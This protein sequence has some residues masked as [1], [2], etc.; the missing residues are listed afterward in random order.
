MRGLDLNQQELIFDYAIGL[1]DPAQAA[2]AR[3]LIAQDIEAA[4]LHDT[5]REAIAPLALLPPEICPDD[6]ADRTVQRVCGFAGQRPAAG[7]PSPRV[8]RLGFPGNLSN[9]A[10]VAI[11][12]ASV[13]LIMGVV[14]RSSVVMRHHHHNQMCRHQL[15]D[16]Y[17][18]LDLY[19]ADYDDILPA[20]ARADGTPWHR[21]GDQSPQSASN[22]RPLFLLFA[23]DYTETSED[24]ICC[25]RARAEVPRLKRADVATHR[26]FPSRHY[27]TYSYALMPH[28]RVQKTVFGARPLMADMNP[29]FEAL[30][31]D[32][33]PSSPP[34]FDETVAGLNSPNHGRRRQGC[35]R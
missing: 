31:S 26:D 16:V 34:L 29:H 24:F 30:L 8:V 1:A 14:M 3:Q 7:E 18:A 12:A 9:A 23:L 2:K 25:S 5:I 28:Q 33:T 22:T 35:L 11:A 10:R 20:V 6:L 27:V 15:A 13:V 4:E 21:I 32:A 17:R 19:T